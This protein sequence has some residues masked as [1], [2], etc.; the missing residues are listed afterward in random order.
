MGLAVRRPSRLTELPDHRRRGPRDDPVL[1]WRRPGLRAAPWPRP[2]ATA[3]RRRG[4]GPPTRPLARCRTG[5]AGDPA[6][7]GAVGNHRR[8]PVPD[9]RR[10]PGASPPRPVARALR[11][12]GAGADGDADRRCRRAGLRLRRRRPAPSRADP[13][14]QGPARHRLGCRGAGPAARTASQLSGT[15]PGR[16]VP[17]A[18]LRRRRRAGRRAPGLGRADRTRRAAVLPAAGPAAAH[19]VRQHPA[20]RQPRPLGLA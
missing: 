20:R 2:A 12:T 17:A 14:A 10:R 19:R 3:G 4:P 15:C 16:P 9:S 11:R 5:R 6:G 1:P 8:Q 18:A 7:P 13:R